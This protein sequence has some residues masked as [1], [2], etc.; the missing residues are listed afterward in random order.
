MMDQVAVVATLD[1]LQY[2][3]VDT[4][5][6]GGWGI[7]ALVGEQTREHADLDLV[8]AQ[9]ALAAAQSALA[10]LGYRHDTTIQPELPARMVLLSPERR[11]IDLHPVVF[12]GHGNGWQPLGNSAWG[13][14]PAEGLAGT[15]LVGGRR[16]R[17]LTPELQLRHHLGYA[18]DSNDCH[19]LRLLG[20]YFRLALPPG[21]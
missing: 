8:V 17:C 21:Y 2:R 4:W 10:T 18:P 6:D 14:Y 12:D 3:S 7:D 13:G 16:V 5:I 15:G 1:C 11:Q 9:E 20:Q 19:D